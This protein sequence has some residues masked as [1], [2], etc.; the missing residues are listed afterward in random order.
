MN[1][2]PRPNWWH[3]NWKWFVPVGCLS[4]LLLV[5]AFVGVL[6]YAIA[7]LMKSSDAYRDALAKAKSSPAVVHELGKPI[8]EGFFT[9][10]SIRVSGPSGDADLSIPI[11]G[12]KGTGTIYLEAHKSAGVWTFSKLVVEIDTD[13]KRV[14]L[15]DQH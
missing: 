9:S 13:R 1:Q 11:S 2:Q 10:G 14:N 3:R 6:F 4:V 8:E 12:P 7:G 15:L 5:T